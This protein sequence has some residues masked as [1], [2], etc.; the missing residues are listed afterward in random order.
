MI[1]LIIRSQSQWMQYFM[2]PA[3]LLIAAA[4][5]WVIITALWGILQPQI[6]RSE[7]RP[8]KDSAILFLKQREPFGR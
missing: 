2:I 8:V 4:S 5:V 3:V 1:G 7:D 6:A